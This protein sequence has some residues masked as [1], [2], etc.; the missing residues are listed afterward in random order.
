[1]V[2]QERGV[3]NTLIEVGLFKKDWFKVKAHYLTGKYSEIDI[4]P[5]FTILR[6]KDEHRIIR[7]GVY[8]KFEPSFVF[9]SKDNLN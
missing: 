4:L 9:T 7:T 6:G 2:L 8:E 1:M 3:I 5:E